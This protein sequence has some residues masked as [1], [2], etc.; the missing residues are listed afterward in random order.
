MKNKPFKTGDKVFIFPVGSTTP[1]NEKALRV[2]VEDNGLLLIDEA[3]PGMTEGD[4]IVPD[5]VIKAI[6]REVRRFLAVPHIPYHQVKPGTKDWQNLK[7]K[8]TPY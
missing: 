2:V 5:A 1:R 3:P 6:R 4:L 7:R 8:P